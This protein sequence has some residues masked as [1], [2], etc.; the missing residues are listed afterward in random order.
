MC[1]V[2]TFRIFQYEAKILN[3]KGAISREWRHLSFQRQLHN[4]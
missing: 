2:N 3:K 1:K 4:T